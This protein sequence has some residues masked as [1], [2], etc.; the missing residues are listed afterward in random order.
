MT[1]L[2]ISLPRDLRAIRTMHADLKAEAF[3]RAA[4]KDL[5]GGDAMVMLG[6]AANLTEWEEQVEAAEMVYFARRSQGRP[7]KWLEIEDNDGDPPAPLL[8]L[9]WWEDR[10]RLEANQPTDLRATIDRAIDYLLGKL[11]FICD[12]YLDAQH[13][14][15][16]IHQLK[17]RMEAVLHDGIRLDRGVPCMYCGTLLVKIW[18]DNIDGSDDKW[19][20]STCE[21]WSNQDQYTQA[22]K[23]AARAQSKGLTASDM[24]EEYRV[25]IGTLRVWAHRGLV[26]KRGKDPSG[27]QLY[28]VADTLAMRDTAENVPDVV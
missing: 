10:V 11:D 6:P 18:G 25:P 7:A 2:R 19:H 24:A 5:P 1:E 21:I 26:K 15:K 14:A 4:S 23:Y 13:L 27:R 20:C 9:A 16:D 8:V 22:V 12:E 3:H 17:M 28:D